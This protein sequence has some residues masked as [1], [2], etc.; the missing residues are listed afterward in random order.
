[1][2]NAGLCRTSGRHP[3]DSLG[4]MTKEEHTP[5]HL[6]IEPGLDIEPAHAEVKGLSGADF[7][8]LWKSLPR[9]DPDFWDD[10]EEATRN[11]GAVSDPWSSEA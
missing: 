2:N 6:P 7:L 10:V 9:P 11:Q 5:D 1:M 3:D 8:A 4:A